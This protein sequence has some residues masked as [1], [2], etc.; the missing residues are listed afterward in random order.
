MSS[1]RAQTGCSQAAGSR[2]RIFLAS[3]GFVPA[4]PRL[5][6]TQGRRALAL[7]AVSYASAGTSPT[8][9]L[10]WSFWPP[11]ASCQRG[12]DLQLRKATERLPCSCEL[13]RRDEP[14]GRL[15]LVAAATPS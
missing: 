3:V 13:R 7:V 11:L 12:R 9:G 5:A 2:P 6:A 8:V 1:G 4:G 14:D 15:T 10:L